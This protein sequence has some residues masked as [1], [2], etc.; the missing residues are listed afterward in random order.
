M[1]PLGKGAQP[2]ARPVLTTGAGGGRSS[3]KGTPARDTPGKQAGRAAPL[4]EISGKKP[5]SPITPAKLRSSRVSSVSGP[6][7]DWR[8]V[9]APRDSESGVPL[10][11]Y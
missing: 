9:P 3:A 6:P 8:P 5:P 7:G 2:S 10:K 4:Q 1:M 11:I